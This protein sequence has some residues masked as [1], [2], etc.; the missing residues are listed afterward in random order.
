MI[1]ASWVS[2]QLSL[3]IV[4][5]APDRAAPSP[6]QPAH[7]GHRNRSTKVQCPQE[8]LFRSASR[9]DEPADAN[10]ITRLNQHPRREVDRLRC[11]CRCRRWSRRWSWCRS[12]CRR[13]RWS[14]GWS[15]S[16][17]QTTTDEEGGGHRDVINPH[18]RCA[19]CDAAVVS[20][21]TPLQLNRLPGGGGRQIDL[22][23]DVG[24]RRS[25]PA[26]ETAPGH[27]SADRISARGRD[28]GVVSANDKGTTSCD[29]VAKCS[30][31]DANLKHHAVAAELHVVEVLEGQL[32]SGPLRVPR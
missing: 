23:R 24:W 31:V 32:E 7:W 29:N 25:R 6:D 21:S 11:R 30:A 4:T 10:I 3:M 28:V 13:W 9:D 12:R 14:R 18:A 22:R 20:G 17:W 27:A 8:H 19:R 5:N 1:S 16:R 2:L 26:R 15:W